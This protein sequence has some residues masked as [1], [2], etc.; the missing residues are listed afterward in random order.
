M[1]FPPLLGRLTNFL[2]AESAGQEISTAS[3]DA[4]LNQIV[5]A[6]NQLDQWV[7]NITQA[8]NR[9]KNLTAA[10]AQAL[11]GSQQFT[12]TA[13]QTVFD[14]SIVWD[15][16]MTA[17][18]TLVFAGGAQVDTSLVT[19]ANNSGNLRVTIPAQ[20]A[21]VVVLV[22]AFTS[23][24]G[25]LTKLASTANALGA[26]LVGIEDSG[27]L[28]VSANVE[29]ALAEAKTAINSFITTVGTVADLLRRDGSVSMTDDFDFG[30]HKATN[31]ADGT[32]NTDAVTLQQLNAAVST[33][34]DLYSAFLRADGS[35]PLSGNLN[36]NGKRITGLADPIDAQDA[37]TKAYLASGT[38]GIVPIGT[39]IESLSPSAPSASWLALDG[40]SK[41]YDTYVTLGAMLGGSPGG[42]FTLPDA[43]GRFILGQSGTYAFNSTGGAATVALVEA[44]N[45]PHAHLLTAAVAG[46]NAAGTPGVFGAVNTT[47]STTGSGIGTPHENMPPYITFYRYV[48][49]L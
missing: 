5:D 37:V 44:N 29:G 7:R 47:I 42:T 19:P 24:A 31:L 9:L 26:S 11:A 35:V 12:A 13:S 23:G 36:A 10:T 38:T 15:S 28:Y 3:M 22:A 39:V 41:S 1:A 21:G 48:K 33:I 4:E 18:N 32:A 2:Q 30:G 6:Y 8:D 27:G 43:R 14:T 40:S 16:S 17:L 34:G 25:V 49:A 45:G 46:G 20:N